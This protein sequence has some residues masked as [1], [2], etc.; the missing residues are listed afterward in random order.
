M[1]SPSSDTAG[2]QSDAGESSSATR[3]GG[4]HAAS[5]VPR[6]D[7]QMS[8]LPSRVDMKNS[9]RRSP[10][11]VG[12]SSIAL[13]SASAATSTGGEKRGGVPAPPSAETVPSSSLR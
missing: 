4:P 11:S 6:R 2:A 12:S 7:I 13:L 8:R 3:T 10:V 1:R 9:S 5:A